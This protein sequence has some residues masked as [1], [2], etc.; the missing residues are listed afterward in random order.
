MDLTK[1]SKLLAN[2][3]YCELRLRAKEYLKYQNAGGEQQ[4]L[5]E[6]TL[7]NCLVGFLQ[8]LGMGQKQAEQYCNNV[9][10]LTELAQYIISILGDKSKHPSS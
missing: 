5:A 6:V 10:N 8:D 9:D 7:Y 3:T 4:Y 2:S 1:L